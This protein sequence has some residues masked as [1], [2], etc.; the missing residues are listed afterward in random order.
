MF[1]R[2]G[3]VTSKNKNITIYSHSLVVETHRCLLVWF[4]LLES[5]DIT[6]KQVPGRG[7]EC[8]LFKVEKKKCNITFVEAQQ[9]K[10][11]QEIGESTFYWR[12]SPY[13]VDCFYKKEIV[14]EFFKWNPI[15]LHRFGVM[16]Q[17][18]EGDFSNSWLVKLKL[19]AW[20][21]T[22]RPLNHG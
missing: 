10:M 7:V 13:S 11:S 5:W 18:S 9:Q 14:I 12:N 16:A 17:V 19:S 20:L 1:K 21:D 15:C 4:S 6:Y 8:N 3:S 22:P 2:V